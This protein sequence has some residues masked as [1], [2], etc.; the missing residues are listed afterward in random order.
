MR[1]RVILLSAA[2]LCAGAALFEGLHTEDGPQHVLQSPSRPDAVPAATGRKRQ[3]QGRFLH[4]TD[5]HP[6]ALYK[7]HSSTD[8]D[9]AC[10]RGHGP[11]G[12]YGAETSDCDTPFS[13]V[14]A[15]FD[16]IEANLK[17]K[18]D[19]VIW[20]GDTARH[21]SD[22]DAPRST[23]Q[24]LDTNKFVAQKF[25]DLFFDEKA[26]AL[27][28]PVIPTLGNNDILPHN[29][30][31]PGPNRWLTNYASI[32]RH[33]I[34][35]EQRHSFQIGGWFYVEVVPNRLAV[36]SLNTLY[37]F[38]RNAA[39]DN[40]VDTSEPGFKQLE[41]LRVQLNLLRNRGM[42][43]IIMGHVPPART[44]SKILWDESCWQKY[45][46]WL[47]QYRDVVTASL[48]GH[49][50]ID[51]FMF[52]DTHDI[53]IQS[54]ASGVYDQGA[55][56]SM[57]DELTAQGA[58]D[59]LLELRRRWSKLPKPKMSANPDPSELSKGKKGD[60]GSLGGR[61]AERY[62]LSVVGPSIV[63]NFFPTLRVIEYNITGLEGSEV[64]MGP[65][66][67]D[68]E[69]LSLSDVDEWESELRAAALAEV[70]KNKKKKKKKKGKKG[71]KGGKTHDPNLVV[72]DPP[73][74]SAPPGPAYSPQPLTLVGYTQYFANLTHINN[75]V[76]VED[77]ETSGRWRDG[78]HSGKQPDKSKP[79]RDFAFEVEYSTFK[80]KILKMSDLT[81]RSYIKLAYRM[82]RQQTKT[83]V[84]DASDDLSWDGG[85][86]DED[87]DAGGDDDYDDDDA[88]DQHGLASNAEDDLIEQHGNETLTEQKN[89]KNKGDDTDKKKKKKK[90]QRHK[91]NKVWL[92]FLKHA[93]VSTMDEKDLKKLDR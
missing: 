76:T 65:I 64:S 63:P 74:K 16:W 20:T 89:K 9:D 61:W 82:G 35:E 19:F 38:D 73:S 77:V 45:T 69:A 93:F 55:R 58:N 30:M 78:K 75:D 34:P 83:K 72:P 88:D 71:G 12:Y 57:D 50:N 79:P 43:A 14:N 80:D 21:D 66:V 48:Y 17:D 28:V 23:K 68:S 70:E 53:N 37:F 49:M 6:D 5:F 84:S 41:W 33:F 90:K 60:K 7:T 29:I 91:H 27:S 52:Q 62:Q 67:R 32:W 42:K 56:V 4:I 2:S 40:C 85:Y 26:E 31:L 3:V 1:R 25:R 92:H 10:H 15:T 13:L 44:D 11:A 8:Q 18:I 86:D 87:G 24:V 51:H 81:V 54:V 36:V 47:Q 59:Y 22:E 39:I 46:L